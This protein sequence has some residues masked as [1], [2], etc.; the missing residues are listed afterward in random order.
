MIL[1]S[2]DGSADAQTAIDH[3]AKLMPGAEATVLTVWEPLLDAMT[4]GSSF[5]MGFGWSGAFTDTD[6][7]DAANEQAAA[8]PTRS[9]STPIAPCSWCPPRASRSAAVPGPTRPN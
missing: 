6:A 5:G 8:S 2:Y 1:M 4:R 7:V 9:S 3:A